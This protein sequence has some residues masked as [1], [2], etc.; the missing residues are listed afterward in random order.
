VLLAPARAARPHDVGRPASAAGCP[1]CPG[2]EAATPPETLAV[3]PG[4]EAPDTPGWLVRAFANKFPAVP[5]DEGVHEVVVTS[6]RHVSSLADLT[7]AEVERA[8]EAWADRIAAVAADPRGLWPFWFL[9]QGGGAGASLQH[10]HAQVVGLAFA[11]PR[12]AAREAAFAA[13]PRS[14][15]LDD[16]EGAGARIVAEADGLVA[17][18]PRVPPL[19]G[20]V[21]IAPHAPASD[22]GGGRDLAPTARLVR[23]LMR[24][25]RAAFDI[26]DVNLCLYQRRPGGTPRYHWHL[27]A[28]PRRG[29]LA[30]LELGAGVITVAQDP[31]VVAERLRAVPAEAGAAPRGAT[32]AAPAPSR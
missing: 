12:L 8:A 13:A 3:R 22:W 18:C 15:L 21:R 10:T 19:S 23:D 11:P 14:P 28:I 32:P 9:N 20:T 5:A 26:E 24:R 17:W 4:G 31:A 25:I 27:D 2:N 30:G 1:F 7:A 29:T 16:L 6:A